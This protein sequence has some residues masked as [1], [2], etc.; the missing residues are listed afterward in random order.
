MFGRRRRPVAAPETRTIATY[1]T[2]GGADLAVVHELVG[3]APGTPVETV[4]R[5]ACGQSAEA[6][7]YRRNGQSEPALARRAD[8][9]VKAWA[10]QHAAHCRLTPVA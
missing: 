9:G 4:A 2:A 7:H 6:G 8:R 3:E 5:C 10:Q 1:R